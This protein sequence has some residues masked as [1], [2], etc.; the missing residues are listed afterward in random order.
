M[1]TTILT[2]AVITAATAIW[3]QVATA[4]TESI[5]DSVWLARLAFT[6]STAA[7]AGIIT[8]WT[9]CPANR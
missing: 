4:H 2:I 1:K 9:F 6:A 5:S 7:L 8:H 3:Y